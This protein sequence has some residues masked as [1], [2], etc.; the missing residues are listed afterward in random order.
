MDRIDEPLAQEIAVREGLKVIVL[1]SISGVGEN[2][3]VAASIRDVASGKNVKTEFVK[4]NGK[5]KVLDAVDTL[6]AAIR[7]DLGESLADR[8]AKQATQ[9]GDHAVAG[10][11]AAVLDR[12]GEGLG[13]PMGRG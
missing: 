1:P 4:A 2:Y 6:S 11:P 13:A 5:N 8:L 12:D 7:K 9:L 10:S 3:R